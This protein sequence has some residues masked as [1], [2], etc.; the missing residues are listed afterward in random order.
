[1]KEFRVFNKKKKKMNIVSI[2]LHEI[3]NKRL[4]NQLKEL[5]NF[6]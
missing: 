6:L 2:S 1:M 5:T 3:A 4:M